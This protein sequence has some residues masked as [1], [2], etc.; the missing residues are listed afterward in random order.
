GGGP[1]GLARLA[2]PLAG[3]AR[4]ARP[5]L[6]RARRGGQRAAGRSAVEP[7]RLRE[8]RSADGQRDGRLGP[9][10]VFREALGVLDRLAMKR[11]RLRCALVAFE[12]R[13]VAGGE[14]LLFAGFV[15]P[16]DFPF[17]RPLVV[18]LHQ[19]LPPRADS[20]RWESTP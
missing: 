3:G 10:V 18:V 1:L 12:R 8:Q 15:L 17:D 11:H 7:R 16:L 19:A 4:S 5:L 14:P 2:L 20:H 13:H 9:V 6:T